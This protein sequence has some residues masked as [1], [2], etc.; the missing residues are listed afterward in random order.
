MPLQCGL[1]NLCTLASC[2]S[3]GWEEFMKFSDTV[4]SA[5]VMFCVMSSADSKQNC[6]EQFLRLENK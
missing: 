1:L 3:I 6:S 5:T 2:V 4:I